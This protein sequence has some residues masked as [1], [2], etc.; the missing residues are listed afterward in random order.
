MRPRPKKIYDKSDE[1]KEESGVV[2]VLFL[3]REMDKSFLDS[4]NFF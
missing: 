2:V 3:V 1:T 4:S